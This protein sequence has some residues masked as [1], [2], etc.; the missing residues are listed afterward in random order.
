MVSKD[1]KIYNLPIFFYIVLVLILTF[2]IFIPT[3]KQIFSIMNIIKI[4][5]YNK[6]E[7]V[8]LTD[9]LI[10]HIKMKIFSKFST[11]LI[12]DDV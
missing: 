4:L 1:K 6:I 5:F 7:Y 3:M 2:L 10:L 9:Y 11:K 12:I 8:I